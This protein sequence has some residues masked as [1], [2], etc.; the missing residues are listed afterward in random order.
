M[1]NNLK[2]IFNLKERIH[3]FL[4][5]IGFFFAALVEIV[6]IASIL[7]FITLAMQ[8]NIDSS[9]QII[10]FLHSNFNHLTHSEL[11][12]Y[13]GIFLIIVLVITNILNALIYW[14]SNIFVKLQAH[15]ISVR[16]LTKY[17][18]QSYRFFLSNNVSRLNNNVITEVNRVTEGMLLP[19]ILA[20][21]KLFV[22]LLIIFL[23]IILNPTLAVIVFSTFVLLYIC[24]YTV[25]RK[26]LDKIGRQSQKLSQE[27]FQSASN[28]FF[29][30]KEIKVNE[31]KNM[32]IKNF[33]N[34][35][36]KFAKNNALLGIISILPRYILETVSFVGVVLAVLYF[37]MIE[38]SS[39]SY[40]PLLGVYAIAGY[41]ILPALQITYIGLAQSR[42]HMPT[43]KTIINDL[44]LIDEIS[45]NYST[46]L[47][48]PF[49]DSIS[50]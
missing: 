29:G 7:P 47:I 21:S 38:S 23:L 36:L 50:I 10:H 49:K 18:S 26:Y 17:T 20:L 35:S 32:F 4:L 41:R 33:E 3:F 27:K 40:I 2:I 15:S 42:F 34:P 46:N 37:I 6:G 9:N 30:I 28:I 19:A 24:I 13:I 1:I 39:S 48:L 5:I 14:Q 16:L 12:Y 45:E 31:G 25:L 43:L 8:K 22:V 11:I 44:L